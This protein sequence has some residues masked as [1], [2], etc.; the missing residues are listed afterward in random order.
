MQGHGL[1]R[2]V[3][4]WL[5]MKSYLVPAWNTVAIILPP[6]QGQSLQSLQTCPSGNVYIILTLSALPTGNT[7]WF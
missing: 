2:S 3:Q 7:N 4:G 6:E 1:A 5:G